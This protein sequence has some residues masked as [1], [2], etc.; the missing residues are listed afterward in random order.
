MAD[1]IREQIIT[2]FTARA[3]GLSNKEVERAK[4][5]QP[6]SSERN[7]SIWDGEDTAEDKAFGVQK[8]SFPI[9]LNMQWEPDINPSVSANA[10]IGET[11]QAM[12]GTDSTFSGLA[13]KMD[14]VTSTPEYP[15]D[16]SGYVSLAVIFNVF[17]ATK[18][19]DP[20]TA[21]N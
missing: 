11:V 13:T 9:A 16:G 21:I 14:Y 1:T 12:I 17:Y 2:A 15:A 6:E 7:V 10:L 19:G 20:F 18:S 3:Q 4:R 5:S 8:L